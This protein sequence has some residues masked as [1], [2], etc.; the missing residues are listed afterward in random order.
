MNRFPGK[1]D[2]FI[3]SRFGIPTSP[4]AAVF[5]PVLRF[6][7]LCVIKKYADTKSYFTRQWISRNGTMFL[8]DLSSGDRIL[9]YYLLYS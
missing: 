4:M 2:G 6:S 5:N 1:K 8:S 9:L 3:Y 7:D